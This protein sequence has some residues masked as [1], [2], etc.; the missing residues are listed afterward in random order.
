M[1]KKSK[2][3]STEAFPAIEVF[4]N[5]H[6]KRRFHI[7]SNCPEYTAVCPKTGLPDFGTIIVDYVPDKYCIELKSFKY[8]L[9]AYR[10][11]GIFYE[12]AINR[13]LRDIVKACKPKSIIVRGEY[14]VRGGMR[15]VVEARHRKK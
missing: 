1:S 8:Y 11:H 13:I 6:P 5:L 4:P 7:I 12:N 3:E 2:K 14:N 10:N 15:S 9:L